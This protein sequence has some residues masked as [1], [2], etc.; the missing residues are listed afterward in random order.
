MN[1]LPMVPLSGRSNMAG[2]SIYGGSEIKKVSRS[3]FS[4][5]PNSKKRINFTN[6]NFHSSL[7]LFNVFAVQI[8]YSVLVQSIPAFH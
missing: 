6:N 1:V 3:Y 5:S 4:G 7:G 8:M 2:R